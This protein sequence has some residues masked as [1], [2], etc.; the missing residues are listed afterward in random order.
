MPINSGIWGED[1][2]SDIYRYLSQS[3]TID[4]VS[5]V[6]LDIE[7][8][9]GKKLMPRI[10]ERAQPS[11]DAPL[12]KGLAQ[13]LPELNTPIK[14]NNETLV[15]QIDSFDGLIDNG[16]HAPPALVYY[17]Y[18]LETRFWAS[19]V[20]VDLGKNVSPITE[21]LIERYPKIKL[22]KGDLLEKWR[23]I[24]YAKQLVLGVSSLAQVLAGITHHEKRVWLLE[25]CVRTELFKVSSDS[26][27]VM[28]VGLTDYF[29]PF[30]WKARHQQVTQLLEHPG[31]KIED[32][33]RWV[34][35]ETDRCRDFSLC[36]TCRDTS[37]TGKLWRKMIAERF[38]VQSV[39]WDCP[40][41]WK[42]GGKPSVKLAILRKLKM[43][44]AFKRTAAALGAVPC[45]DCEQRGKRMDGLRK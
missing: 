31:S 15:L 1:P 45:E 41:G 13:L 28:P 36:Q 20:I 35:T 12:S 37:V 38:E 21:H 29:A 23:T 6:D 7:V 8:A 32:N 26:I 43:G 44:S 25:G 10:S 39:D 16:Q 3:F 33:G 19:V 22:C 5:D 40:H 17:R 42:W 24:V 30:T 34:F 11:R 18:I 9:P 27:K 4:L 2:N 14:L